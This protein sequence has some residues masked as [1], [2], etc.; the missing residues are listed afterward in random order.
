MLSISGLFTLQSC[1]EDAAS[2]VKEYGSFTDPVLLAPGN[3]SFVN[4]TGTTVDLKW[5]SSDA[6]G[7]PQK[8]DVY[9]GETSSPELIESG[10]SSQTITVDVVPGAEYFWRV[11][12]TDA[13]GVITRGPT[14]SFEVVDP[15][16]PL[17]MDLTWASNALD[18]IGMEIDPLLVA[19]L[20]LRIYKEDKVTQ[21]VSPSINTTGFENYSGWNTLVDGKYW[22]ETELTSTVDAGDF[23]APIDINIELAF[24]QR[25]IMEETFGFPAVMTNQ[26]VCS[27][28]KVFLGI[29]EKSGD[30]Y[31]FTK[32]VTTPVSPLSHVWF[33]LDN[34]GFEYPS[35]AETY[36]GCSLQI[37]G[38]SWDWM[39]D[40]WGETIIKGGFASIT[41]DTIAGEVTIPNQFYCRTKWNGAVQ[42]DYYIEGT[43]TYEKSGEFATMTISYDLLQNGVSMASMD[44]ASDPIFVA[45]LTTDPDG[46]K[47]AV[48]SVR[49]FTRPAVKPAQR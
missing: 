35:Q 21:A 15:A 4:V 30:T 34:S 10:Y 11:E 1:N 14:W 38:L 42:P 43:G 31:A 40:Y 39:S 7:D 33:G 19:N 37:K 13:H 24:S 18:V 48:K 23:N 27:T 16:A 3:E 9:F 22:V 44:P 26:F 17:S 20:R 46:K 36:M 49:Q 29:V 32:E 47:G 41:I 28:Y 8:W 12:I 45:T 6:N 25:G 2:L 5:E